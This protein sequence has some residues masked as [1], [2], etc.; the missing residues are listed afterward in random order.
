MQTRASESGT[1]TGESSASD[2]CLPSETSS[3]FLSSGGALKGQYK[4][5][6]LAS[7]SHKCPD[8]SATVGPVCD[9]LNWAGIYE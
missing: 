3:D 1:Q 9:N 4:V 6:V 8:L 2:R 5:R 7:Q